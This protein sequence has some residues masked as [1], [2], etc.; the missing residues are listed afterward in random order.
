MPADAAPSPGPPAG[1]GRRR[2]RA[3]RDAVPGRRRRS[4]GGPTRQPRRAR[5]WPCRSRPCGSPTSAAQRDDDGDLGAARGPGHRPS[6]ARS[7][8]TRSATGSGWAPWPRTTSSRT[9]AAPSADDVPVRLAPQ[10]IPARS[11]PSIIGC[12][13]PRVSSS[14]PKST[15]TWLVGHA[16]RRRGPG[17][18]TAGCWTGCRRARPLATSIASSARVPPQNSPRSHLAPAR[19]PV[20]AGPTGRP[21]RI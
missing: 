8:A 5:R 17:R 13:R 14:S 11:E 15:K 10:A 9:T 1:R 16:G 19:P 3:A 12:G 18:A 7:P 21:C 2:R 4:T 20:P 6:P